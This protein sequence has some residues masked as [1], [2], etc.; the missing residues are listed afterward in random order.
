M[1]N[2]ILRGQVRATRETEQQLVPM[3]RRWSEVGMVVRAT[4]VQQE[5]CPH[6]CE[7]LRGHAVLPVRVSEDWQ[8]LLHDLYPFADQ[9][10][11]HVVD[12]SISFCRV[13]LV[14][15]F[16]APARFLP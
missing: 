1:G 11:T 4:G 6:A 2:D 8:R 13:V 3:E 16:L 9:A 14:T 15:R 12:T 7:S 10:R 5:Q